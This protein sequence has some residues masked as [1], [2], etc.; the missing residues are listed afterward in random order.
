MELPPLGLYIHLPWCERK[1]PYCDFNSHESDVI[2]ESGYI[3]ALLMQM[4]KRP[5]Q[6]DVIVTCNMF[7]DIATDLGAQLAGGMGLAA[8]GNIHPV[9]TSLFEPVHGSAPD[10]A[11]RGISNPTAT[12]LTAAMMLDHLAEHEVAARIDRAVNSVLEDGPVTADLGGS[13]DTESFTD[14]LIEAYRHV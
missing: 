7:G 11:G 2:P 1:C 8:S 4:V 13:A 3:D 5:E 14:A 6:F 10:I 9:K 12:I